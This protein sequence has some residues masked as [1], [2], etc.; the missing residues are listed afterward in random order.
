MTLR[1]ALAN[2]NCRVAELIPPA[3][4]TALAGPGQN[5]GA[6]LN[7]FCDAVF[8]GLFINNAGQVGFGPTANISVE[9]SGKPQAD[10]FMAGSSRF[11]VKVY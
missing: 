5:H 3:V 4:Q 8:A 6:P 11:P 10:L 1:H 9:I 7:E 2:T